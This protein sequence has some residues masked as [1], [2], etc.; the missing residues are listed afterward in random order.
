VA[1]LEA[2]ISQQ[3]VILD[4]TDEQYNQ[5]VVNLAQTQASLQTTSASLSTTRSELESA[6]ARLRTEAIGAYESDSTSQAVASL[7]AAP[8]GAAQTRGVYEGIGA[9]DLAADVARVQAGQRQLSATQGKLVTEQRA[10]TEQLTVERQAQQSAAG[11]NAQSEATLAEVKGT[12]AQQIAQQAAAQAAAAAQSAASAASP[13][14]AAAAAAQAAQAAQVAS[15]LSGGSAAAV[16]ATNSANQ[17]AGLAA[18][19]GGGPTL[20]SGGSPQAAGLA[21]VH[22]AMKYLGVPYVWGGESYSGV[23]CSGLTALAW[24][25][26]GVS[27]PHS[28]ADQYAESK[29][30]PLDQLEPGDLL[31]YDFDGSGIDHVVMYVGPVL[32]GQPTPFGSG[33]IIQAAHTGTF[34]TYDPVWYEGLVGAARP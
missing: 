17:A 21:A 22:G 12:L 18:G 34:V 23:D 13:A 4:Q 19:A 11:A 30:V 32:D 9:G 8:S 15:T 6:R 10:E 14:A 24:A 25:N 20:T 7:F 5:A 33:T 16:G 26:A 1:G 31:F 29:H 27:L 2:Q 3:Q 28:A